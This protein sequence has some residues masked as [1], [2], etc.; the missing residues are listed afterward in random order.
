MTKAICTSLTS[1][2]IAYS[3]STHRDAPIVI[4]GTGE[5]GFSG[6]GGPATKA[7]LNAPHDLAFD[8]EGKLL[9]ADT[10]NHRIRRIDRQGVITT[11]VG[12]GEAPYAG[13]DAPAPKDTT[14]QSPGR[15]G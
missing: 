6:D 3:N 10:F 12:I 1:G 14:Q 5:G 11:V 2:R 9:I 13:Y 8:T 4:A 15:R 7:Q